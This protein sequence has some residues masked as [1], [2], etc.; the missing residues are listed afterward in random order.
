[1]GLLVPKS[2]GSDRFCTDFRKV[3]MVTKPQCGFA[4]VAVTYLGMVVGQGQVWPV[5]AKIEAKYPLPKMKKE[6]K[7]FLGLV[8]CY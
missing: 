8:R 4:R 6:L 2:D 7:R 3:N 1:M 5:E